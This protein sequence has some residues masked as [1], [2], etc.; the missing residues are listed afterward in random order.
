MM[1][2]NV[3]D[4]IEQW[5]IL[6]LH[7][8]EQQGI[9]YVAAWHSR[10]GARSLRKI[11]KSVN[12]EKATWLRELR[13]KKSRKDFTGSEREQELK[14]LAYDNKANR[15]RWEA[16]L[17][18][19]QEKYSKTQWKIR[20]NASIRLLNLRTWVLK[21]HVPLAFIIATL[22]KRYAYARR[23][24]SKNNLGISIATL[25]SI[26]SRKLIE[27][28]IKRKLPDNLVAVR[29]R[30]IDRMNG[31]G[32]WPRLSEYSTVEEYLRKYQV[33]KLRQHRQADVK[34]TKPYRNNPWR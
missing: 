31:S 19:A 6:V 4:Q 5:A 21:Y 9:T 11:E 26:K 34:L 33:W 20:A 13:K 15:R 7:E 18:E 24:Y 32:S 23:R 17:L 14:D 16:E 10:T 25:T 3:K 22:L 1:R 8:L 28:E 30:D 29:Q 27:D 2:A 12:A